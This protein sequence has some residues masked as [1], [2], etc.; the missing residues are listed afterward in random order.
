MTRVLRSA[1]LLALLATPALP[2]QEPSPTSAPDVEL[3]PGNVAYFRVVNAIGLKTPT[4]VS[5]RTGAE[6]KFS[7][8]APGEASGM[9]VLRLG[10]YNLTVTNEGCEKPEVS[11]RIP[12]LAGGVYTLIILYTEPVEKDGAI[13]HRLQYAK[14]ERSGK[15]E[16]PKL[17]VVSLVNVESLPVRLGDRDVSLPPRRAQHFD[18]ETDQS[19]SIT[20]DGAPVMDPVEITDEIPYLVFLFR[21]EATGK[22]EGSL[23]R[24]ISVVLELPRSMQEKS[25]PATPPPATARP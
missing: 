19:L 17:S 4:R 9:R 11:D 20:H 8:M 14:L 12:L 25:A 18:V 3:S 21:N 10:S 24:E 22:V 1:S 5:F 13:V 15:P 7:D 2:A 16:G 6:P 23:A